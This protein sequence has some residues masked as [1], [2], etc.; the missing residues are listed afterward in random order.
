MII[1]HY[2]IYDCLLAYSRDY[3]LASWSG[4]VGKPHVAKNCR[5]PLGTVV[6]FR[7]W[8]WPPADIQQEARALSPTTA[9][10]WIL[11]TTRVSLEDSSPVKPPDEN[12]AQLT[13]WL[14]T[15]K[16]ISRGPSWTTDPQRLW[17]NKLWVVLNHI[18][19]N[20]LHSN[21]KLIH[22]CNHESK[23]SI[24]KAVRYTWAAWNLRVCK[25]HPNSTVWAREEIGKEKASREL[26][27]LS[28]FYKDM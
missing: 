26:L 9:K 20:L 14:Q 8:E 22:C 18:C 19:G 25:A 5:W 27:S 10:K 28:S 15:C 12:T 7:C 16:T 2:I 1:L 13:P 3:F 6:A 24:C 23:R 4:H 17:D 11:P 21:R